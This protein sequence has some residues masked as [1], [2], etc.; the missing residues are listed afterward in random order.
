MLQFQI[1]KGDLGQHRLVEADADVIREGQIRIAIRQFALTS[2]NITCAVT[3]DQLGYWQF[4]PPAGHDTEGWGVMPVWGFGEVIESLNPGVTCGARIYGFLPSAT[5][6][7]ITPGEVSER[8][9]VDAANHRTKLPAVY[10]SYRRVSA[11]P[12]YDGSTDNERMLLGPL[13]TT[14]WCLWDALQEQDWYGAQQIVVV[15]ASSKTSIGLSYA[16]KDDPAAPTSIGLTSPGN[17]DFVK[18]LDTYDRGA[19]YDNVAN[20]AANLPT[21]I[22]DMSGNSEVLGS[23]HGQ[24]GDNMKW[25]FNVGITHWEQMG[26]DD[27]II[28][29]RSEMFFAPSHIQRRMTEWGPAAFDRKVSAFAADVGIRSRDWMNVSR[30]GGLE[31][32]NSRFEMLREGNLPPDLGLIIDV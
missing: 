20:I 21:V 28:R 32:M 30:L 11:D 7:V 22:V 12:G 24:L 27:R 23:L 3:G 5:E 25:C 8:R 13:L 31:E 6:S 17:L 10:N 14:S 1:R 2:N 29:D 26:Q 16:L 9:I 19:S 4:F 15:S 18:E